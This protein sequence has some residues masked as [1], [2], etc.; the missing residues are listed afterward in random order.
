MG[1]N[2]KQKQKQTSTLLYH[3]VSDTKIFPPASR[4]LIEAGEEE[5]K[6]I[7]NILTENTWKFHFIFYTPTPRVVNA[8]SLIRGKGFPADRVHLRNPCMY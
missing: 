5:K 2:E 8:V 7:T 4:K 1:F 3:K 6:E